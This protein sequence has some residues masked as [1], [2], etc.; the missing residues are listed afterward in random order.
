MKIL[1]VYKDFYPPVIGGMERHIALL[2]HFQKQ[3]GEVEVL[4]CARLSRTY[5]Y[6]HEGIQITA[7]GEWGRFQSAPVAPLFPWYLRRIP[8]DVMVIHTPNPTAELGWLIARPRCTLV[9]RYQ[10]DVVRQAAA[11][12]LYKP[13]LLHFL[14]E[15]AGI[16]PTSH[17]YQESSPILCRYRHKCHVIPLGIIPEAFD[18]PDPVLVEQARQRYGTPYVFYCGVHRYYKGLPYLIQAA[19]QI[20]ARVV[21]AGDGPERTAIME[22]AQRVGADVAFPGQLTDEELKAHLHGCALAVFPS[23]A[24]SEAFG[25]SILDAHACGRPVVATRLGTGVE[26]VNE[27]GKT[28]IN[29]SPCDPMALASAV[30]V[31]LRDNALRESMGAYA[32]ERVRRHF[33]AEALARQEFELYEALRKSS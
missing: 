29:V 3:W 25:L 33:N 27:D 11:M 26:F 2:C 24:R 16:M 12:R 15:A 5:H 14:D 18:S 19:P 17:Q 4:V 21:V 9:V 22:L 13:F 28:G 31:L 23:C 7:V 30:N 1:H 8:A 32:R 6:E 20:E 10:S